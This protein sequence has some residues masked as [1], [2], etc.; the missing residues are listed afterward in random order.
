MRRL[1]GRRMLLLATILVGACAAQMS[2]SEKQEA[3]QPHYDIGLG[4]LAENNTSKA[5]STV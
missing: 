1:T 5:P 3:S 4:A 2:E